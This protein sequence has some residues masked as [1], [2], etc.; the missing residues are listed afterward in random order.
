MMNIELKSRNFKKLQRFPAF[1]RKSEKIRAN[2]MEI[3]E[4]HEPTATRTATCRSSR[5]SDRRP[6]KSRARRNLAAPSFLKILSELSIADVD[7]VLFR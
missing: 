4:N 2:F 6:C 5:P 3:S 7:N 1:S